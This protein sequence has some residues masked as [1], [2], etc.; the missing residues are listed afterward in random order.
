MISSH[1]S[2]TPALKYQRLH[3][4]LQKIKRN[5]KSAEQLDN[6]NIKFSDEL[7]KIEA[8]QMKT[9]TVVMAVLHKSFLFL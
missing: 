3:E 1:T 8:K 2:Q 9:I 4:F 5:Q 6:W 7:V